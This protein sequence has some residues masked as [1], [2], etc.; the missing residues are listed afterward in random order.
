MLRPLIC[1]I[2]VSAATVAIL[3]LQSIAGEVQ[4]REAAQLPHQYGA[5]VAARMLS[6]DRMALFNGSNTIFVAGTT[7]LDSPLNR[8]DLF[9][10]E[11]IVYV[12]EPELMLLAGHDV[13]AFD[14]SSRRFQLLNLK[15]V[16]SELAEPMDN[17]AVLFGKISLDR[18]RR[19]FLVDFSPGFVIGDVTRPS[20]TAIVESTFSLA[21]FLP[22]G[23]VIQC[24]EDHCRVCELDE[25]GISKAEKRFRQKV[26]DGGAV[27][28]LPNP[29]RLG[30]IENAEFASGVQLVRAEGT[31]ENAIVV[32][33]RGNV[34][35][36]GSDGFFETFEVWHVSGNTISNLS[37]VSAA[38]FDSESPQFLDWR[39]SVIVPNC[40]IPG[41]FSITHFFKEQAWT[42]TVKLSAS[43]KPEM[44]SYAK[45][46]Y[47]LQD[48]NQLRLHSISI[49]GKNQFLVVDD[50]SRLYRMELL[51]RR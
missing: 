9:N 11:D 43:R 8:F 22:D 48:G 16:R 6:E 36:A 34:V 17:G 47:K 42:A 37:A 13:V 18:A 14:P 21:T 41:E 50:K 39:D 33:S 23:R 49:A 40:D 26:N 31:V 29:T 5:L 7:D 30:A 38:E 25:N 2:P 46:E 15:P 20:E 1:C 32:L 51:M 28:Q 24:G 19:R 3:A 12:Q 10:A 44:S 27:L 45:V 4:L 35:P